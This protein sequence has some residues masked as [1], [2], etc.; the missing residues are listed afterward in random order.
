MEKTY[1]DYVIECH[2]NAID[3]QRAYEAAKRDLQLAN[4]PDTK[5]YETALK[6]VA[7]AFGL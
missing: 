5:K 1:V 3:K 4:W 2:K 7:E 6:K